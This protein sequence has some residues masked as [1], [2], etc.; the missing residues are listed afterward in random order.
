M[1][2][3]DGNEVNFYREVNEEILDTAKGEILAVLDKAHKDG[4]ISEEEYR[5]MDPTEKA[6]AR[7]YLLFKVHKAHQEGT[8][9]PERPVISG[10]GSITENPSRFCQHYM[11]Q[12]SKDHDSFIRDTC[13]FLR[14]IQNIEK[15]RKRFRR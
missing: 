15:Q 1:K 11:K 4:I 6:A 12:V 10:S 8:A 3:S 13:D 2:K 7:L 14:H 9:P 5:H